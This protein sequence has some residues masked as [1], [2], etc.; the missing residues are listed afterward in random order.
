[1]MP[2]NKSDGKL[3]NSN[4]K[5]NQIF[6]IFFKQRE[7]FKCQ[8]VAHI[9]RKLLNIGNLSAFINEIL[10]HIRDDEDHLALYVLSVI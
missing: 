3:L 10:L 4:F 9:I 2:A 7:P 6:S 5:L 1:M 8:V